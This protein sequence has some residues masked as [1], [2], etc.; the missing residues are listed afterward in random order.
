VQT[1]SEHLGK[2]RAADIVRYDSKGKEVHYWLKHRRETLDLLK[3]I[4]KV[5]YVPSQLP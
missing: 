2:L 1:V 5:V 4:E 3:A